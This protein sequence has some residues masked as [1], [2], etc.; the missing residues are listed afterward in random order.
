MLS[1]P[2]T[3]HHKT[4][5][6]GLAVAFGSHH[7]KCV[8]KNILAFIHP[9]PHLP[10]NNT[11][12][13]AA[14][15]PLGSLEVFCGGATTSQHIEAKDDEHFETTTFALKR[16][17]LLGLLDEFIDPEKQAEKIHLASPG[18]KQLLGNLASL[19]HATPAAAEPPVAEPSNEVTPTPASPKPLTTAFDSP[20]LMPHDDADITNEPQRHV[21]YLLYQWDI[22]DILK[23]WRYIVLK[24]N[25]V[26]NAARLENASWRTWAQRQGNLKTINPE[27]V[28]WLKDLDVTW[29]Y[30]PI[31]EDDNKNVDDDPHRQVTVTSKEAGDISLPLYNKPKGIIRQR[32][33]LDRI[34]SHSNLLKHDLAANR[35]LQRRKDEQQA[36]MEALRDAPKPEF[37][38]Y[39]AITGRLNQQYK[40]SQ[41]LLNLLLTK[42]QN[43]LNHKIDTA[44]QP[45]PLAAVALPN[46]PQSE[47][48]LVDL[49]PPK[50]ERHIHFDET[51]MQCIAVDNYLDLDGD[52]DVAPA[53]KTPLAIYLDSDDSDDSDDDDKD[54]G[55]FLLVPSLGAAP[56]IALSARALELELELLELS[57][58]VLTTNLKMELQTIRMLLPTTINYGLEDETSDD[59]YTYT[60]LLSHKAEHRG[61]DYYYNYDY[62]RVY[63][64][65]PAYA[66]LNTPDVVDCP[67]DIAMQ[68]NNASVHDGSGSAAST[69]IV[70]EP[71]P[72]PGGLPVAIIPQV[73]A[74]PGV[75]LPLTP[76]P[77]PAAV[78][79]DLDLDLDDGLSISALSS[80]KDL[81]QLVFGMTQADHFPDATPA[82]P[83][84]APTASINP[85]RLQLLFIAKQPRSLGL[86]AALFF[87]D[88]SQADGGAVRSQLSQL[89]LGD[90]QKNNLNSSSSTVAHTPL[91]ALAD[92]FLGRLALLFDREPSPLAK[93]APL[94]PQTSQETA[95]SVLSPP[96]RARL[97]FLLQDS[98]S[99]LDSE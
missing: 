28:N 49:N 25:T 38:D 53:P 39:H 9:G 13:K 4:G 88:A 74:A 50:P 41:P 92:L 75:K 89:F 59:E 42:L 80:S 10:M 66:E 18:L 63:T 61:Y 70:L 72:G 20:E 2:P 3:F 62:D 55:F 8:R 71:Q 76:K 87:G 14:G 40:H 84:A 23:L 45:L 33:R 83:V 65:H 57:D 60:L 24:R 19:A 16:T 6:R 34:I 12:S 51:V 82:E 97:G 37:F 58:S 95:T 93:L 94:P 31:L 44:H 1:P 5:V 67:A 91:S 56:A 7:S 98:D 21:D 86:L 48:T 78:E 52:A 15:A 26:T 79:L 43:L 69:P 77:Q 22:T 35:E 27:V 85:N 36:K 46:L 68:F 96:R 47:V 30:G 17:P 81:A 54:G 99:E 64:D 11:Q 73:I 32:L 90:T 29:L